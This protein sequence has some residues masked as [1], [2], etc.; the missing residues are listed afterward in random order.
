MFI[1]YVA[2]EVNTGG[3]FTLSINSCL[4]CKHVH[5]LHESERTLNFLNFKGQKQEF[6][7]HFVIVLP[8]GWFGITFVL[9][10]TKQNL[11]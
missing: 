6:V 8:S 3:S 2:H 10:S 11:I 9:F 7:T 1:R 4:C 5:S